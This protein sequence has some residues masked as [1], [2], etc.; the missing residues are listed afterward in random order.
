MEGYAT[1]P[2]PRTSTV[3]QVRLHKIVRT[4]EVNVPVEL[5]SE[6]V[7]IERNPLFPPR[8]LKRR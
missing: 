2:E 6:H 5:K 1:T 4:E 8:C 3:G 7:V